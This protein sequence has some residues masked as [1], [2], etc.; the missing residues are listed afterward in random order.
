MV[1]AASPP[2][3]P[4]ASQEKGK[5]GNLQRVSPVQR[6]Q[7]LCLNHQLELRHVLPAAARGPGKQA[8]FLFFLRPVTFTYLGQVVKI[9][10]VLL[11]LRIYI[12][13]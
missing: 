3:G 1:A 5:G 11:Y 13:L 7:K 10:S 2:L 4:R 12:I 8:F 6:K 9:C